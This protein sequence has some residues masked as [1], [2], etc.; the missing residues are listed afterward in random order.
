MLQNLKADPRKETY[1]KKWERD[2]RKRNLIDRQRIPKSERDEYF[3]VIYNKKVKIPGFKRFTPYKPEGWEYSKDF[4]TDFTGVYVMKDTVMSYPFRSISM[5]TRSHSNGDNVM[6]GLC[7]NASQVVDLYNALFM[8]SE[9]H[10]DPDFIESWK[11]TKEWQMHAIER[12]PDDKWV[13]RQS[14][15]WHG[16]HVIILYP[17]GDFR[18]HKWGQYLGEFEPQC[19]YF[20]EEEGIEGVYAFDIFK[21]V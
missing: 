16:N 11:R 7:D 2:M 10:G 8:G 1:W 14:N 5:C 13:Q 20:S 6:Y 18:W 3:D 17:M 19:E 12:H 4:L 21:V 15:F 9:Y